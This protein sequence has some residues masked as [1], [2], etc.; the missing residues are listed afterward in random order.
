MRHAH[1]VLSQGSSFVGTNYCNGSQS[2]NNVEI[3]NK[4]SLFEHLVGSDCKGY[5]ELGQKSFGNISHTNPDQ[6]NDRFYDRKPV[7]KSQDEEG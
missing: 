4:H 7:C 5:S 6:E 3:I 1:S 2:F